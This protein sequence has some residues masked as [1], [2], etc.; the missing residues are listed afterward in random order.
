MT[1]HLS[2]GVAQVLYLVIISLEPCLQRRFVDSRLA[3]KQVFSVLFCSLF[4]LLERNPCLFVAE[5]DGSVAVAGVL[6]P[7]LSGRVC[8]ALGGNRG[9]SYNRSNEKM[10]RLKPS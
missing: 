6:K 3:I 4:S 8:R 5:D 7:V 2:S 1:K 10:S 9:T